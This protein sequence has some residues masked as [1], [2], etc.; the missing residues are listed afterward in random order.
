MDGWWWWFGSHDEECGLAT[1]KRSSPMLTRRFYKPGRRTLYDFARTYTILYKKDIEPEAELSKEVEE[2]PCLT[3]ALCVMRVVSH[4]RGGG[5]PN[6]IGDVGVIRMSSQSR[7]TLVHMSRY[8]REGLSCP[9]SLGI[10]WFW[11]PCC[12]TYLM[13]HCLNRHGKEC[14]V[15]R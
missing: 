1:N 8:R 5:Q 10:S 2:G 15:S 3:Q 4:S 7:S 14:V 11:L 12:L 9:N 6:E 13:H